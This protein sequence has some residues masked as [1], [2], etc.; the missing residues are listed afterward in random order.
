MFLFLS[1]KLK[2]K[3]P[4]A[5]QYKIELFFFFLFCLHPSFH[6]SRL[7]SP[8]ASSEILQEVGQKIQSYPFNFRGATILSGQEEGAYGWVTVNYLLENFIKVPPL[9]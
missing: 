7:A 6:P 1:H 8:E 2:R 5:R 9:T 4:F 3:S